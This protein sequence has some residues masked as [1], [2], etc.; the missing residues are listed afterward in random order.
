MILGSNVWMFAIELATPEFS[1]V[2]TA[3]RLYDKTNKESFVL[4]VYKK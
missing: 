4:D 3:Y 2:A 1:G